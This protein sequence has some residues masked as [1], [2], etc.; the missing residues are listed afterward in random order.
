MSSVAAAMAL[1]LLVLLLGCSDGSD[2]GDGASDDTAED[3]ASTVGGDADEDADEGGDEGSDEDEG[4]GD[5]E[6]ALAC[7]LLTADDLTAAGLSVAS[8]PTANELAPT[9]ECGFELEAA[10]TPPIPGTVVV[11]VY[12]PEEG[13]D[14]EQARQ[15]YTD[16]EE[17]DGPATDAWISPS[18]KVIQFTLDD[19]RVVSIQAVVDTPPEE[20]SETLVSLADAAAART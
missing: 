14:L 12:E 2:D 11:I 9:D 1:G 7:S 4:S 15:T 5:D 16:L 17:L 3:S 18:L 13:L 6:E 10:G 20:A 19:G 8:G